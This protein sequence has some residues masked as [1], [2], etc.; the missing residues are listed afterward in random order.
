[1]RSLQPREKRLLRLAVGFL[2]IYLVGFYG[3]ELLSY[4][5]TR[6]TEYREMRLAVGRVERD[7]LLEREK[8]R[9]VENL[10]KTLR[11]DLEKLR[12]DAV[13]AESLAAIQKA[14]Q[15]RS[16]NLGTS[17]EAQQGPSSKELARFQLEGIGGLKAV[18]EFLYSLRHL[19]YPLAID[20]LR[21]A[22]HGS[23]GEV[24]FSV[25]VSLFSFRGWSRPKEGE[26]RA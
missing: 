15:A 14:A 20:S 7:I 13:V 11:F 24:R 17:K 21:L 25:T 2:A 8:Q 10:R 6:R 19:G 4:L 26:I 18:S 5:E 16:V 3:L 12:G 9:T 22:A 23:P 1:M